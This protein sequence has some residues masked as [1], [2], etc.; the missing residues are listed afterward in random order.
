[1]A[2]MFVS[3]FKAGVVAR[4]LAAS[5]L[6]LW[7]AGVGCF[8]GCEMSV[9]ASPADDSIEVTQADSCPSMSG[10]DCCPTIESGDDDDGSTVRQTPRDGARINCC[11]LSGQSADPARKVSISDAPFVEAGSRLT[12]A[13]KHQTPAQLTSRRTQVPDRGSTRL[14]CCVFL[15]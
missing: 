14:R 10:H 6:V 12:V 9:A 15:I 5:A 7:L 13:P 1:M 3:H 2:A 4:R 11:P 8:L